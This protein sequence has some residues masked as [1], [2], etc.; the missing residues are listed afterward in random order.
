LAR[1]NLTL[2]TPPQEKEE[3]HPYRRPWRSISIE[4]GILLG[5]TALL[6]VLANVLNLHFPG[7]VGG[8]ISVVVALLPFGLWLIFSWWAERSVPQPRQR[9]LAVVVISGL[10]A[11]AVGIP[12]INDFL[13]V[14]R[15]LP[16]ASAINR[17][18]G[19]TFTIGIVQELLKYLVVRYTVWPGCYRTRTD[20]IA[21][22]AA[23]AVGYATV[24]N[25][26]F[27]MSNASPP[28]ITAIHVFDTLALHLAT[29]LI[30]G[31]GLAEIRFGLPTPLFLTSTLALA[32]FVTGVAIPVRA[33]LVN[34]G[35]SLKVGDAKTLFSIGFALA[36][37]MVFSLMISFLYSSA[38]RRERESATE[39]R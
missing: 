17:I 35:F 9:L 34:P 18:V 1:S 37:L 7:Q 31:Y 21:Y 19:Y 4:T 13:Q 32:S 10:V 8:I 16:L 15:W 27:V 29:S 26:H 5:V 11:N 12:F 25:L 38:E 22:G 24:L 3:I 28:S 2:L 23:S 20:A 36:L 39:E 14:D 30:M 6:Y 33:G